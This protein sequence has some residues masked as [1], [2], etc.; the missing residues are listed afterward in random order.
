MRI[1]VNHQRRPYLLAMSTGLL[2]AACS[3]SGKQP[4]A[5][6]APAAPPPPAAEVSIAGTGIFPES[7][8]SSKDGSVYIGSVGKAQVYKAAPGAG[9]A[10]VF[11]APGTGGIKQVFGVLADDASS[12]LWVCSNTVAVGG[13]P[14]PVA[15]TINGLYSFDLTSGAAKSHYDFPA[16]GMC[17]DIAVGGNGDV[18]ATDTM[19]MQV[20]RLPKGGSALEVWSPKGAFGPAGGVLDGIAVV[21][22]RVVANTLVTS[23]LFAVE[24]GADGK[25]GKVTELALTAPGAAAPAVPA[26]AAGGKVAA[27]AAPVLPLTRPDGMR[28]WGIDGLLSTDGTGKIQHVVIKGDAAEVHTVKDGLDGVVAVTTVGNYA[29]ALEGQLGIMMAQPGTTPPAE[30]PYRAVGFTLP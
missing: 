18:Y 29:Y 28:A 11:I 13:P 22:N 26:P 7:M 10:E 27:P 6:P 1:T 8:T 17:N 20:L 15:G 9:T 3:Q 14:G 16:G 5:E 30:K 19:G 12:T 23:K 21:G 2:L 4:A 25:A 24:I